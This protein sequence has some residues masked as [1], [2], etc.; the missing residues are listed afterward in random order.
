MPTSE[1]L[2]K[3]YEILPEA[4]KWL[5]VTGFSVLPCS[6]GKMKQIPHNTNNINLIL[7]ADLH[8]QQRRKSRGCLFLKLLPQ[9][10][11]GS[12]LRSVLALLSISISIS[13]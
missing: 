1:S 4:I 5:I 6:I 11:V 8:C 2:L 10:W 9:L 7:N 13:M 12:T 3:Y